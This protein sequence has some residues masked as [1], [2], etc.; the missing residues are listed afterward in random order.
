MRLLLLFLTAA[1]TAQAGV[2][3]GVVIENLSGRPLARTRIRLQAVPKPGGVPRPF[4]TRVDRSGR[5]VFLDIPDGLYLLIAEREGYFPCAFGTRRPGGQGKPIEVVRDSSFF[6]DL[7]ML[8]K[9]AITGRVLDENGVGISGV[10]VWAYRARVPVRPAGNGISDDRG[11]YRVHGLDPGKYWVRTAPN[12]L[13]DG[14]GLLPTFG[15]E[16]REARE[17]RVHQAPLDTDT[18]D[19][20]VRPEPGALFQ[21]G[22]VLDCAPEGAPVMLTLSSET[23]RRNTQGACARGYA[24]PGL[25]PAVYQ[26]FA[27][28]PGGTDAGF[29]ELFADRDITSANVMLRP[30]PEVY[31]EVRRGATSSDAKAPVTITGRRVDL[32]GAGDEREIKFPRDKL[33]P[34]HWELNGT[35]GSGLYIESIASPYQQRRRSVK[36]EQSPDAFE[37]FIEYT[38]YTQVRITV[39]DQVGQIA[40]NVTSLGNSAPGAPVFL[41]P[42]SEAN[43]RSLR[44]WLQVLSDTEGHYHFDNLPKGDYRVLATF[45]LSEVDEQAMDEALAVTVPV[46][47]AQTATV[48]LKVWI[49]P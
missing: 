8:R 29:L 46:N 22:G 48:D 42:V 2:V 17:A 16:S 44:G 18:P 12:T 45:D 23:I 26:V 33:A 25:S 19:A 24:F 15:P 36:Q 49:A 13:D 9:A 43:R 14:T 39:S 27:E 21:L 4:N 1:L 6:T 5:F 37:I 40:G 11:V 32:S 28:K 31:F 20:D 38:G 47:A 30:L 41:W 35:A 7:R 3:Q 34:G 10:Q